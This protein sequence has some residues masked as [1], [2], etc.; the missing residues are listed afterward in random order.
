MLLITIWTRVKGLLDEINE[1][2]YDL[3]NKS[4]LTNNYAALEFLYGNEANT[5][6]LS[7]VASISQREKGQKKN[8]SHVYMLT[9]ITFITI[10]KKKL[11]SF[12]PELKY[13][14]T[15]V[16]NYHNNVIII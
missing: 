6:G 15:L 2:N 14:I 1:H 3:H 11:R 10:K 7:V 13:K 16:M 4:S 9:F 12:I 8:K 5:A